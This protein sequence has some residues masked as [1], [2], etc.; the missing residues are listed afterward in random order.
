MKNRKYYIGK[1]VS[2]KNLH[3]I[4]EHIYAGKTLRVFLD[5][6]SNSTFTLPIR[7]REDYYVFKDTED[8]YFE[9]K[10]FVWLIPEMEY[11]LKLLEE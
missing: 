5:E 1:V 7:D 9:R 6:S 4:S 3:Y 2:K 10:S 8:E 11:K